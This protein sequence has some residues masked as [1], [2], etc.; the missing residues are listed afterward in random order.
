MPR[1]E[2][3]GEIKGFAFIDVPSEEDIVKA[4]D[5]LN[6][7]EMGERPLRVSK[8]LPK[9]QIRSKKTEQIPNKN[10]LFVGNLSF[11]ATTDDLKELFG[12]YGELTDVYIPVNAAGDPRGFAFITCAEGQADN[13]LEKCNGIEFMGRTLA[14][15]PPLAPGEKKERR[16]RPTKTNRKKL[17][18]GN[19]SFYTVEETLYDVFEEFGKVHDVYIPID[20]ERGGSRGFGFVTMDD[21]AA[22]EAVDGLDGCEIDGR[23]IAVNEAQVKSR[24][25]PPPS[26]NDED[27]DEEESP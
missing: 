4:V 27:A 5:A 2:E 7:K 22:L 14:V 25:G 11:E 13:I 15:N 10:K 1:N 6:G 9:G 24:R 23:I 21:E 18:V 8:V 26:Y 20:N 12:E 3:T 16:D 19:L 17:Y